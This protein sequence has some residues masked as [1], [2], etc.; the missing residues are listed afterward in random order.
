MPELQIVATTHSPYILDGV[1]PSD[2]RVFFPRPDGSI[3]TKKLSDHPDAERMKDILGS[4]EFWSAE[5]EAWVL[6]EEP[7]T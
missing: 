5:S 6:G 1:D 2:V 3:V 7:K 4:G